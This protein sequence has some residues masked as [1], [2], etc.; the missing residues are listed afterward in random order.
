MFYPYL[1]VRP[2]QLNSIK[3]VASFQAINLK[4]HTDVISIL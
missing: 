2:S 3:G 1:S 4:L